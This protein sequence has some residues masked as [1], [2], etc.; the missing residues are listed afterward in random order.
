MD[1]EI[2]LKHNTA[3]L[4]KA[5]KVEVLLKSDGWKIFKEIYEKKIDEIKEKDNYKTF[6]DFKAERKAIKVLRNIINE[7]ES[8]TN[9][10]NEKQKIIEQLVNKKPPDLLSID[11]EGG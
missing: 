2:I 8:I 6:L 4:E 3:E 7:L 1:K 5:R 10:I 11:G 9:S